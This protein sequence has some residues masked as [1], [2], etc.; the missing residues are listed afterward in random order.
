M[1]ADIPTLQ[2]PN[3]QANWRDG[4]VLLCR[5]GARDIAVMHRDGTIESFIAD[6]EGKRFNSPNDV[7]VGKDRSVWFTDPPLALPGHP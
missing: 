7:A 6:Y 2:G 5:H 4:A 3:G 1:R